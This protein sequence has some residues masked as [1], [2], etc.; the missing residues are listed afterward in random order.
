MAMDHVH[1]LITVSY[2]IGLTLLGIYD[3][4]ALLLQVLGAAFTCPPAGPNCAPRWRK[5]WPVA[6]VM[7]FL[8]W[9]GFVSAIIIH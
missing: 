5:G 8:L 3:D 2:A 4:L 7:Y 1:S 9:A 6:F